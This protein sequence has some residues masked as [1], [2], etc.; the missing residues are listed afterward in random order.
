MIPVLAE[1]YKV[2]ALD[3]LGFGASDKPFMDYSMEL[4]D[5]QIRDF[6]AEFVGEQP[7]VVV[8]NSVGSLATLMVGAAAPERVKGVVLLN[9]AGEVNVHQGNGHISCAYRNEQN[10]KH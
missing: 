4:W 10:F 1:K 9:C 6:M 8:G 2:Y 7:A 3:L 5:E